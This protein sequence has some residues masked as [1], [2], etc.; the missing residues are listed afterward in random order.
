MRHFLLANWCI[1]FLAAIAAL[2]A[3]R[4]TILEMRVIQLR[5]EYDE[6]SALLVGAGA[7]L[8]LTHSNARRIEYLT[9][10][11]EGEL[12]PVGPEVIP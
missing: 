4:L 12:A 11:H 1:L 7:T 9:L 5:E 2:L 3:W 8:N 6:A 10:F